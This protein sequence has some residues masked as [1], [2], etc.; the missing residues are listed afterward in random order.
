M[1]NELRKKKIEALAKVTEHVEPACGN[2]Y[3]NP[4]HWL[5]RWPGVPASQQSATIEA[6]TGIVTDYRHLS[7]TVSEDV[8]PKSW[9]GKIDRRINYLYSINTVK[10]SD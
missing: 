10:F 8:P 1:K 5:L 9:L 6:T 7:G 2:A 4:S 3:D